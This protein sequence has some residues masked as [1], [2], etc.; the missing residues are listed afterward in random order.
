MSTDKIRHAEPRWF[1]LVNDEII[2]APSKNVKVSVLRVL[3]RTPADEIL[4]RDHNSSEDEI[5]ANDGVVDLGMGNVFYSRACQNQSKPHD[6]EAPAKLAYSIDDRF[7]IGVPELS[8]SSLLEIFSLPPSTPLLRDYESPND[9]AIGKTET[10]KFADGPVFVTRCK[11]QEGPFSVTI[12]VEG[13]PH[14]WSKKTI[15]Y[16]EVVKL[17]VPEYPQNPPLTYAVKYRGGPNEKPEGILS[18]GATVKVK[19]RMIFNVSETGQS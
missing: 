7:E 3:A 9:Q 2:T 5:L 4:Y 16:E 17:E 12:I 15:A 6:C 19:D 1:A 18:P 13:T 11:G 14:E 8:A 10:I